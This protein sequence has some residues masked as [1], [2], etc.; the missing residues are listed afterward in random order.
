MVRAATAQAEA[1]A[2]AAA[3]AA[4]VKERGRAAILGALVADAATMPLHWIYDAPKISAM[5]AERGMEAAPEFYPEPSCPFYKAPAG[6][7]SQSCYGEELL[8]LLKAMAEGGAYD[9]EAYVQAMYDHFKDPLL[10]RNASVRH[11]VTAYE[12]GKR[13][14]ECGHPTDH[15]ANCFAKAAM[16]VARYAGRPELPAMVEAAVRVQ[17]NNDEAVKYGLAGALLLEKVVLGSTLESALAWA[18]AEG[19]LPQDLQALVARALATRTT[20]LRDLQYEVSPYMQE[21]VSKHMDV[22]DSLHPFTLAVWCNGPA[23]GNPAAFTNVCM[24]AALPAGDYVTGV[25]RNLLA[26]GD[27]C[28]RACLIGALFAAQGGLDSIPAEWRAKTT[29]YAQYEQWAAKIVGASP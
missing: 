11:F 15:Q 26:A 28:S 17:Q 21:M 14:F 22:K 12:E 27:N 24:T 3:P 6:L 2:V 20:P 23:C 1:P 5:L 19:G 4:A 7:G 13:G 29:N 10:Y 16:V 8:P 25:R 18:T 9:T